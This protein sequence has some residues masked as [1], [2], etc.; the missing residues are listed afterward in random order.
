MTR[1]ALA[2]A[3]VGITLGSARG[4]TVPQFVNVPDSYT[5]GVPFSFEVRVPGVPD[6]A[7]FFLELLFETTIPD[8]ELTA[9]AAPGVG[10]YPFPS[11]AGFTAEATFPGPGETAFLLTISDFG[12]PVTTQAGVSDFLA[13]VTV[14]PGAGF[15]G[16]IEIS[17]GG[18]S[19]LDYN[20]EGRDDSF[21]DPLSVSEAESTAVPAPA[22]WLTLALG[23]LLLRTRARLRRE[24]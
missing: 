3:A 14:S 7:G 9:T 24:T 23:G 4:D 22:G 21:P 17:L 2:V 11:V 10:A 12:S 6:F 18:G 19:F 8:P 5:P 13:T 1:M 20:T 15:S 16:P